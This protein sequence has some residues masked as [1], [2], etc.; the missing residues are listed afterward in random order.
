MSTVNNSFNIKR[1][2]QLVCEGTAEIKGF[3]IK[4]S[5]HQISQHA[6]FEQRS[7]SEVMKS[8]LKEAKAQTNQLTE[9]L[10]E[11]R[12]AQ[13]KE[14]SFDSKTIG[15]LEECQEGGEFRLVSEAEDREE[16]FMLLG[17]ARELLSAAENRFMYADEALRDSIKYLMGEINGVIMAHRNIKNVAE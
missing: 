13:A 16:G 14:E 3:D 1:Q 2:A 6:R 9:F 4:S 12:V 17:E 15:M 8:H 11:R 10:E 7:R 5:V